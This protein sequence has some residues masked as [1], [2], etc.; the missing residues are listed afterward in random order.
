VAAGARALGPD[1]FERTKGRFWS[2]VATRPYMRA[3]SELVG[4]L[5]EDGQIEEACQLL[6]GL[7]ELDPTDHE[8][9]RHV[10]LGGYLEI[11]DLEKARALDARFAHK[12]DACLLWG[13]VLERVLAGDLPGAEAALRAAE[14]KNSDVRAALLGDLDVSGIPESPDPGTLAEARWVLDHLSDAWDR[15]KE[16]L[17]WLAEKK[18]E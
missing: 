15:H 3:C 14:E 9:R 17:D 4:A 5:S 18:P 7:L 2:L 6:E 1:Y 12:P 13:R 16:A 8:G 11:K 10:L